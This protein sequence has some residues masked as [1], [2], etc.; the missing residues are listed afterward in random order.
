MRNM[1]ILVW[2]CVVLICLGI[3][4]HG[5]VGL[6]FTIPGVFCCGYLLLVLIKRMKVS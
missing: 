1:L 5:W 2:L 4:T 3:F 6:A